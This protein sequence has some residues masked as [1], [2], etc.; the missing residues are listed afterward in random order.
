MS[1]DEQPNNTTCRLNDPKGTCNR[2]CEGVTTVKGYFSIFGS[3]EE[4]QTKYQY[5]V[6]VQAHATNKALTGHR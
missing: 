4:N 5:E 2:D 6:R 3:S 1:S